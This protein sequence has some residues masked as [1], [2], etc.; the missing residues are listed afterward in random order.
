[1]GD[2]RI[3]ESKVEHM[4]RLT[5]RCDLEGVSAA[6]WDVVYAKVTTGRK[7]RGCFSFTQSFLGLVSHQFPVD[8]LDKVIHCIRKDAGPS[9]PAARA[10]ITGLDVLATF[11][12]F[13]LD[14]DRGQADEAAL[15]RPADGIPAAAA[16]YTQIYFVLGHPDVTP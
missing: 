10:E 2:E 3:A 8:E 13:T 16:A 6:G 5:E 14:A 7:T 9:G 15:D 11:A 12:G 4:R 1:M